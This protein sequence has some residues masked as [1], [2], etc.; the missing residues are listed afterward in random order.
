MLTEGLPDIF[1]RTFAGYYEQ[2]M[3]GS[4]GLIPEAEIQP[5]TSLPDADTFSEEMAAIGEAAMSRTAV[6]KLNGGL[7]TSMGL[8]Q[9]KSLLVVKEGLSFLDIIA[10]QSICTAVPLILMDS[11]S[12]QE[13]SRHV[14]CRYPALDKG[15][16]QTFLQH[17][18]PK[19]NEA[20]L[21][22]VSWPANPALEW[23]PPGHG[24]IYTALVT[25]GTLAALL[26]QGYEYAF[27]SNADN[28]GAVIDRRILGYFASQHIPFMMEV[29]NRTEMDRKGGHLAQRP[30][31]QLILRESAQCPDEDQD[32]FQDIS[33]YRYFNTNNLWFH[34][35][36]LQQVMQEQDYQ[37]GL[38]IIRNRKTVDPRDA[39]STAVYQLETAMGSAIAIFAGAQAVRVGRERFAPV[40]T[41]NELLAVRSDAYELTPD[42]RVIPGAGRHMMH[43]VVNLDPTYYKFHYDLE[44][45]F[46]Y[47]TPS[48]IQCRRFDVSG[49]VCFGK[50]VVCR[51]EVMIKNESDR[52][53]TIPDGTVLEGVIKFT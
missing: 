43:F 16:P 17:K 42:F 44:A 8:E 6:I 1:I 26:A 23:C 41:T 14:F 52:Q 3:A 29:A 22:P 19:I 9:A 35:P 5:V 32:A 37:L 30:D 50:G 48:L 28:L 2:L 53:V 49:D 21:T 38:P 27:V 25:S 15:L 45:R 46:P 12:T 13:D 34:L 47:G 11:F 40:K 4:T 33:R 7:G 36:S 10:R 20:D 31:G 39:D 51:G 18:A 24:D